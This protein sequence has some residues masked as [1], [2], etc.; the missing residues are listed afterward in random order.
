MVDSFL[1]WTLIVAFSFIF[2]Y[3]FQSLLI[4]LLFTRKTRRPPIEK[5]DIWLIMDF[6]CYRFRFAIWFAAA[7]AAIKE[8]FCIYFAA[9]LFCCWCYF[10]FSYCCMEEQLWSCLTETRFNATY[11]KQLFFSRYS[12]YTN[13]YMTLNDVVGKDSQAFPSM[14][15][16]NDIVAVFFI[17]YQNIASTT[18]RRSSRWFC[19]FYQLLSVSCYLFCWNRQTRGHTWKYYLSSN[20]QLLKLC[21]LSFFFLF[22]YSIISIFNILFSGR[23]FN[24]RFLDQFTFH[25][26]LQL[27]R[28][29]FD[30]VFCRT[31]NFL[32][33]C[34][35]VIS[36]VSECACMCAFHREWDTMSERKMLVA[37]CCCYWNVKYWS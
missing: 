12:L 8:I 25:S 13:Q 21:I 2:L 18:R 20:F 34:F 29:F 26:L 7:A 23:S 6:F 36:S 3:F 19:F 9:V 28:I 1:Y 31:F 22:N 14:T 15:F 32:Y 27:N 33:H 17:S 24:S 4:G 35:S 30:D 37:D 5:E 16:R 10:T 11:L